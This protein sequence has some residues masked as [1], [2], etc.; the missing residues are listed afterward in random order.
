MKQNEKILKK[1][2]IDLGFYEYLLRH[3]SVLTKEKFF[4]NLFLKISETEY[5]LTDFKADVCSTHIFLTQKETN[6]T[7]G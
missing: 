7:N 4:H 6:S 2:L 3:S 1:I 5:K